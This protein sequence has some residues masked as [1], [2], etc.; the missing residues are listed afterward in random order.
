M[1]LYSTLAVANEPLLVGMIRYERL[2][3]KRPMRRE[4]WR[5]VTTNEG[6]VFV[7]LLVVGDRKH[8]PIGGEPLC[9]L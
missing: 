3:Q 9:A 6:Q 7:A 5:A 2:H 4:S 8:L 1:R